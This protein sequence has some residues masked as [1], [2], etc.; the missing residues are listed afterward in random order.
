MFAI[1][2]TKYGGPEV[3]NLVTKQ[4]PFPRKNEVLIKIMGTSATSADYR[5]RS[6]D[7]PPGFKLLGRLIYG[8]KKPKI[9][10]LG[11]EA[12]GVVESVGDDVK[13]FIAGDAVVFQLGSTMGAYQEYIVID[14]QKNA[15][16]HKPDNLSFTE[17]GIISFGATTALCFLK[18]KFKLQRDHRILILGASGSVGTAAVQIASGI[19]AKV[20]AVSRVENT[21]LLQSLGANCVIDY[22]SI[23]LN[24]LDHFDVIM[25]CA[26]FSSTMSELKRLKSGGRLIL[27]SAGLY[28]ILAGV[29]LTIISSKRIISGPVFDTKE[30]LKSVMQMVVEKRYKAV[31]DRVFSFSQIREAHQYLDGRH[32]KGNI[33]ID[34]QQT[35]EIL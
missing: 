8:W 1:E 4:K 21:E 10:T 27:V 12:T 5:I 13:D 29:I 3:L 9:R 2:F 18:E 35:K 20:I 17:A 28:E 19:G 24:D 22:R 33:A 7:F 11:G 32:R 30:R 31:V 14:P 23:E 16:V 34:F 6:A 25:D 15:V 26:G